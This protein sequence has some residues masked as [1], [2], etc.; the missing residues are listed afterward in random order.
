MLREVQATENVLKAAKYY[1][2]PLCYAR[3]PPKQ[4]PP[5]SGLK[6]TEFNQRILVDSHWIACEDSIVKK[7]EPAPGTP[8]AKRKEKDVKEKRPTGRQCVLTVVDH[9]TRYVAIRILKNEKA[10]EFTKGLERC[11]LKHFGTP[12]IL[13]IDEA[14]GWSSNHVRE[15]ATQRGISLE[16]Q[17]AE[18]HSWLGVVERKHQVVR[19]ALELYMD[20]CEKHD[21]VAL[22]EAARYVP[23]SI[24][25]LSFHKGLT[26]QQWVVGKSMTHVHGLSGEIFNPAQ[27]AI[28][29]Q[30]AFAIIQQRRINAAKAFIAADSDAKLRRAF[31]QK[32]AEMQ[33]DLAIGQRVW[34]WRKNLRRL[35]KSGW[36][37]PAR[38]VAIEEQ[39][40]V[41][42]YW[43]CHGTSLVRCGARQVRP[44]VEDTGMPAASDPKAALK[45]LQELKARSTTQFRDELKKSGHTDEVEELNGDDMELDAEYEPTDPGDLPEQ[46]SADEEAPDNE[47]QNAE[48]P[49]VVSIFLPQ[50]AEERERTPR[51]RQEPSTAPP[52][53]AMEPEESPSSPKRK[54]SA[55]LQEER[56]EKAARS[57]LAPVAEEAGLA[58]DGVSVPLPIEEDDDLVIDD[59]YFT[60]LPD[61]APEGWRV[62]DGC[63]ELDDV[64]LTAIRKGEVNE[65]K[66]N[67][68]DRLKFVDGKRKELDQY[69]NNFVWKFAATDEIET[70]IRNKRVITAR[71]VL[72]WKKIDSED[73]I[74][75]WRAKARLVLRGFQDPDILS[76]KT[77]APTAGR[78]ART[79]LLACTVWMNWSLFCAD[80]QAAFLSGKSFD[81]LL[82]VRLPMDCL[83]LIDGAAQKV[84]NK[85][86]YMKMC[87]SAYGLC[88]APLLWYEEASS[89]LMKRGWKKH[90][91]DSCCFM[92]Q[93]P[94][95][96]KKKPGQ[97]AGLIIVHVDDFLV[98]GSQSNPTFKK[99]MDD[100][101]KDFAFG[102]W[103]QL[104]PKQPLKYCGGIILMNSNHD[105]EVSYAEYLKKI[106][107]MTIAKGRKDTDEV[108]AA[109]I[110][111]ARGLIGAMQ[112]PA[113]Q[114]VPHLCASMSIQ[115]GEVPKG[116]V[117]NL[118]ELN[119]SLRFAKT[120]SDV[121]LKFLARPSSKKTDLSTLCLVCYA[122]AAFCV[123]N[124]KTS[125][126]G[127]VIM[128]CEK[129]V[130]QGE[131]K[132]ASIIS[133]RSFKVPRV[134]RSSLA[135]ECQACATALEELLL[136]KT[137]LEVL[138]NP[139][140]TLQQ[141]KDKLEGECAMVTD[142]KAL[143][144]A[145]HRETIQQATDKRVAIEGLVIK[146]LLNDLHCQWRWVSSERQLSDGLTKVGARQAFVE[147]FKGSYVQLISDTAFTASKKKSK[148]EREKTI[149]ETRSTRT[150]RSQ[151]AEALVAL[152]MAT[153]VNEASSSSLDEVS[154]NGFHALL[155]TALI[156]LLTML[157][158]F[159]RVMVSLCQRSPKV[160]QDEVPAT[161]ADV[162][163]ET[164]RLE[165]EGLR[166]TIRSLRA[167]LAVLNGKL[168]RANKEVARVEKE[169]KIAKEQARNSQ[170]PETFFGPHGIYVCPHGEVW[171]ATRTCAGQ[172]GTYKRA[173]ARCVPG[174]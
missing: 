157:W 82:V 2:C 101:Q 96:E 29:E 53:E 106:C 50:L 123:R 58:S 135:A 51:R 126:G 74:V 30:G 102:K 11:W 134:C 33:E 41:N 172:G 54:S 42:V 56:K 158:L 164:L 15:W 136:T 3:K 165:N 68:E 71:W 149:A 1:T 4:N 122:D 98:S 139:S 44:M 144:D 110:S 159:G 91:I 105:I 140:L 128:A 60:H 32:F 16:V 166:Q 131:K 76:M 23:H 75:R 46:G 31:N 95:D 107:P 57:S 113:T 121:T 153:Q 92:L 84:Y 62:V 36:R 37:G 116:T 13:R 162:Q 169:I 150:S 99:A 100:L 129:G 90:P 25:Q 65:R 80:V 45:D 85:H 61:D 47:E 127:Y 81:R 18:N 125:Q 137:F 88:D 167:Q 170:E 142:C 67:P 147:R 5:A 89:R 163:A 14:K 133:W 64:Y 52:S 171:H 117:H 39:P 34:Y 160:I 49:G 143:Y 118:K 124:D 7:R 109:E 17:P 120:N 20:Q 155:I 148:E 152:V 8:A 79:F 12:Q 55:P 138:K 93:D 108:T 87:K 70:A 26:P 38:I 19:R 174:G 27:E 161:P 111:A 59:V 22:K 9:A 28:D 115:A 40:N 10:E 141:V 156:G 145:V 168:G 86:L 6:C 63:L 104:T 83:P 78:T 130:L 114:G 94:E 146:D 66:L 151:V 69:F 35:Q 154:L 72:T 119:K 43:L 24:N 21:L 77:A 112:W 103:D 173:C 132:P 73:G 97:L 48:V